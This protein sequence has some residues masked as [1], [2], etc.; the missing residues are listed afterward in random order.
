MGKTKKILH[1]ELRQKY[2]TTI[3][4]FLTA[5]GEEV[6]RTASGE[7]SIPVLDSE[8]NE[9]WVQIVIKVPTGARDDNEGYDGFSIAKDYQA[10]VELD[11]LEAEKAKVK[12]EKKIAKDTAE[13]KAKAEARANH[14]K[15]KGN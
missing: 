8:Q 13:R 12:K 10:K 5:N 4:D 9:E 2:L 7:I 6:L 14:E 1:A 11:A 3:S 15:E